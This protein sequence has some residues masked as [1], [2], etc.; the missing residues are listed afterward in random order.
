[1]TETAA[2]SIQ[3]EDPPAKKTGKSEPKFAE[4]AD[5]LRGEPMRWALFADDTRSAAVTQINKGTLTAFRPAGHFEARG[6]VVG[7]NRSRIWARFVG[8]Q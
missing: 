2:P 6:E 4:F 3:W 5:A 1:M 7:P 8:E